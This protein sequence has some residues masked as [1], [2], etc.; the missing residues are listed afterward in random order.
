MGKHRPLPP[1]SLLN[2]L[3]EIDWTSPSGLR[4]RIQRPGIKVGSN[5]G[6]Q[7]KRGYWSVGVKTDKTRIYRV[8]RIIYFMQSG[9]DPQD[10]V[11]DHYGE[12]RSD[13]S[14]IRL[15]TQRLNSAHS[16]KQ[17]SYK[18]QNPSSEYK[19]VTWF[20]RNNKWG[21]QIRG[22][23]SIKFLGLFDC[24]QE[25]AL[26][27]NREAEKL[28]KEF[29]VLNVLTEEDFKVIKKYQK[30]KEL[31]FNQSSRFIGVCWR[32]ATKKWI[33]KISIN[34][35]RIHLGIF[36]KEV[37]AAKAYNEAAIKYRGASARLN[38]IC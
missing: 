8:H 13:N 19:G 38:N 35:K 14:K 10:N 34:S 24:E 5:A 16:K 31:E 18:K 12:D 9:I 2:E 25:A 4:W 37:D 36:E 15:T 22:E 3:F 17:K 29:A 6:T 1:L 30:Q 23:G 11:I 27:Y 21:A 7:S 26:A 28:W 20:K 33:A 32:K